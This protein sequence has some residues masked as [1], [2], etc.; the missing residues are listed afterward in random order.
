VKLG[1]RLSQLVDLVK[2]SLRN[3]LGPMLWSLFGRFL[4]IF[5]QPKM[6]IF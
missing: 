5:R 6:A 4:Q 1:L 3:N 2:P